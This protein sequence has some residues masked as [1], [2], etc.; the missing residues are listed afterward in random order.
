MVP[1]K[2]VHWVFVYVRKRFWQYYF[3]FL[4]SFINN[5]TVYKTRPSSELFTNIIKDVKDNI[6]HYS[7]AI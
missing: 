7:M 4:S 1:L 6:F 3:A 2:P 5:S